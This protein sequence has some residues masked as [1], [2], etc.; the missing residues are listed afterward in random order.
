V[1]LWSLIDCFWCLYCR[2]FQGKVNKHL[3]DY[4]V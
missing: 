2:H 1:M 3:P 4:M